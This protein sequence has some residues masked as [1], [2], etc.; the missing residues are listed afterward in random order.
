MPTVMIGGV[1]KQYERGT[2][3]EAIAREYQ[4]KYHNTIALVSMNGKMR[5]LSK[6]LE[7][8]GAL[9][10]ITTAESSGHNAYVRT[11][12]MMMIKAGDSLLHSSC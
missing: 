9:R 12:Q 8:D 1:M 5:E 6:R 2:T 4:E 10:F 3:F 7:R 11:A